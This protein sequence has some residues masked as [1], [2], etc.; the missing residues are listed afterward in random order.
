[1]AIT[2]D[3]LG[4]DPI[5]IIELFELDTT[6]FPGG[7]IS[8]FH[9]GV[10]FNGQP[11]VWQGQTYSALPVEATG[12]NLSARG[13]LPRPRFKVANIDGIFSGLVMEF[14]DLVGCKVIRK[15]TYLK[16]LD[17]VNFPGGV[18]PSADPYQ[19]FEDDVWYVDRK[20]AEN[21]YVIEWELAS[22]F[23]LQ[24][25]TLPVRQIIQNTCAWKYKSAECSWIP[26]GEFFDRND[27]P[28]N[29]PAQDFCSKRLSGCKVRFKEQILPYGGFPGAI[30][31]D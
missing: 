6:N 19:H 18:N 22:A 15:R 31:Y 1:M 7:T 11:V 27:L 3:Y 28:T 5:T 2:E 8:R 16:Y 29:D 13:V 26:N 17:A 23:D 30:R 20:A 24:G 14:G 25:V 12:F 10:N 9:N 21:K 4:L